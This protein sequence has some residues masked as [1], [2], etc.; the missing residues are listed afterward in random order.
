MLTISFFAAASLAASNLWTANDPFVGRWRLD[1]SRSIIIDEMRV[2]VVGP[3]ISGV[4]LATRIE[5]KDAP[6]QQEASVKGAITSFVSVAN[7][8]VAGRTVDASSATF[9]DGSAAQLAN[10]RQV[11]V[12][13][14]LVGTVLR[15]KKVSFE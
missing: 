9:E 12:E 8:T 14:V 11:E 7:F 15:A 1:V 6:E 10:G 2:Q 4:L 3:V 13:G 5:V